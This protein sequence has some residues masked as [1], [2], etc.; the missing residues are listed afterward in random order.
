MTALDPVE[1]ALYRLRLAEEHLKRAEIA[2]NARDWPM[3]VHFSQLAVENAAKALIA[4]FEV[5]IRTHDPSEQL[6]GLL[7]RLPVE[8]RAGAGELARA[9]HELAPE[10]ARSTYGLPAE[11]LTPSD[12]YDEGYA[13]ECVNRARRVLDIARRALEE[14]LGGAR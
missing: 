13:E 1:E 11:G 2:L 9:A 10:H 3:T 7:D 12:I 14:L 5:P 6:L 8:L 4:V